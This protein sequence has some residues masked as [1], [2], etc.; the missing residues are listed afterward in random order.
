MLASTRDEPVNLSDSRLETHQHRTPAGANC[1]QSLLVVPDAMT[2]IDL[3]KR[4][5]LLVSGRGK[6][7]PDF[8]Y[9]GC[10]LPTE[11]GGQVTVSAV[12][13][14]YSQ[15]NTQ[16]ETRH[17]AR[18]QQTAPLMIPDRCGTVPPQVPEVG[19]GQIAA[20]RVLHVQRFTLPLRLITMAQPR[21]DHRPP[22]TT[23]LTSEH[24][25][26][27]ALD[28]MAERPQIPGRPGHV[29]RP[30][31][32]C[33]NRARSASGKAA[34]SC[35][36]CSGRSG[37]MVGSGPLTPWFLSVQT[38]LTLISVTEPAQAS[39]HGC[40]RRR[41]RRLLTLVYYG[42]RDGQVRCLAPAPGKAM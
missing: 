12:R 29:Q 24:H 37:P 6:Y 2:L 11:L 27:P 39:L 22:P 41:P 21:L 23:V 31:R 7:A 17:Q 14:R 15:C 38:S 4:L 33:S 42:L 36:T 34:R 5:F 16:K 3:R 10:A 19:S 32:S 20:D 18:T 30:V 26:P 40:P 25:P 13:Q 35:S 1:C 8:P 28:D 9:H